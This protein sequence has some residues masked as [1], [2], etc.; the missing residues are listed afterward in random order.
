MMSHHAMHGMSG[1]CKA[2]LRFL[3]EYVRTMLQLKGDGEVEEEGG[4]GTR[5]GGGR[6]VWEG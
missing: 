6:R 1:I 2:S 3:G 5:E 4:D